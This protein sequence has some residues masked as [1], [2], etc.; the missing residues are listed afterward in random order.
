M[1]TDI[2]AE[3]DRVVCVS[4][5]YPKILNGSTYLTLHDALQSAQATEYL[6]IIANHF[7]SVQA[8]RNYF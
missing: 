3:R 2:Y 8:S 1:V 7:R 5:M 6:C 4:A